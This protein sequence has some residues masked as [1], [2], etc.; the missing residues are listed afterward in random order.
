MLKD[1][2]M[3][4]LDKW[5]SRAEKTATPIDDVVVKVIKQ[6]VTLLI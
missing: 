5:E 3:D 2:L 1:M 6:L 4:A